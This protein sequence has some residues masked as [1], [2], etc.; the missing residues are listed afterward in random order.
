MK[1]S[2]V[3]IQNKTG[4]VNQSSSQQP[5]DVS[6]HIDVGEHIGDCHVAFVNLP[7]CPNLEGEQSYLADA[8][9]IISE[10]RVHPGVAHER[11][12]HDFLSL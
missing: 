8:V 10:S 5:L 1:Q 6:P 12:H 3:I 9:A 11:P 2:A 4:L 7:G